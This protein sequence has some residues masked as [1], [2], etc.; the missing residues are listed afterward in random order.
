MATYTFLLT[1]LEGS[2]AL[3]EKH[4]DVMGR[5]LVRMEEIVSAAVV[6]NHGIVHKVRG[7]GDSM[8]CTFERAVDAIV[9]ARD[10]AR[11]L[12]GER[13]E[14]IELRVRAGLHT[15]EVPERDGEFYGGTVNRVARLRGIAA[16][17]QILIS[18]RT[19]E[20]ASESLPDDLTLADLGEHGLR[21][22]SRPEHVYELRS[23]GLLDGFPPLNSVGSRPNN[24]PVQVS[25]FVGREQ[26]IEQIA[27]LVPTTPLITLTA[28]GGAG[29]TR[30]ALH[31]SASLLEG[32]PD[33]VWLV[34]LGDVSDPGLLVQ[35]LA[36]TVGVYDRLSEA[37]QGDGAKLAM[38]DR[39][40]EL[41]A[42]RKTLIVLD[43]C[44]HLVAE[45]AR[46]VDRIVHRCADIRI[47]ATSREPL[48]V[49]GERVFAVPSLST[50]GAI[51]P[52]A[53][54]FV[55]RARLA[56]PGFEID[57]RTAHVVE[58][59]LERLD[60]LPLAIEL[61]ASRLR[62]LSIDSLASRLDDAFRVLTG[63]ARAV[64]RHRTLEATITWSH[65]L[66]EDAEKVLFRRLS[67]FAGGFTLQAAES[68]CGF[69]PLGGG[70]ILDLLSALVD[71]SLVVYDDATDRYR[72][73][74]IVGQFANRKLVESGESDEV[75][76]R[77]T[78]FCL[79]VAR[80]AGVDSLFNGR[81]PSN[82]AEIDNVRS[83]LTRA[84]TDNDR[85]TA[86]RMLADFGW[87][88]IELGLICEGVDR[89]RAA[90]DLPGTAPGLDEQTLSTIANF[91][92]FLGEW[93]AWCEV[94]TRAEAGARELPP[95]LEKG[96]SLLM[97]AMGASVAGE[98]ERARALIDTVASEPDSL[99]PNA[100]GVRWVSILTAMI[101]HDFEA[102]LAM[103]PRVREICGSFGWTLGARNCDWVT[104][105]VWTFDGRLAEARA[106]L[107][108]IV[109][110]Q[111]D[112]S[113]SGAWWT[114]C[115][116]EVHRLEG[117]LPGAVEIVRAVLERG[118]TIG[119][120]M[121]SWFTLIQTIA[122]FAHAG[123]ARSAGAI[124]GA[125]DAGRDGTLGSCWSVNAWLEHFYVA[126]EDLLGEEVHG[127]EYRSGY[128][129]GRPRSLPQVVDAAVAALAAIH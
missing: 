76:R 43:N 108:P 87:A 51:S 56:R 106:L 18:A 23:A 66:L 116:A 62:T 75:G 102:V 122:L 9:G 45:S 13:P 67:V 33:G 5:A 46:I 78:Q 115:L 30:L 80:A 107:E 117:D 114:L 47:I 49:D 98:V 32:F 29:K 58:A 72:L 15:G 61:A 38:E 68:V 63:G 77:H 4:P 37:A 129:E 21:D 112:S 74:H 40:L 54:L 59:V 3:W 39:A 110:D 119:V 70:D 60:G 64:E 81:A 7:E 31:A 85:Q 34:R 86:L 10:F 12:A 91:H 105:I 71:R 101:D 94:S 42:Q 48:G 84:M 8:F 93:N 11:Q 97:L 41:L 24:L 89:T 52:A 20:L 111:G 17:G 57:D 2:T 6:A 82:A 113:W 69:E 96:S 65:D 16:G 127:D 88:W 53:Q 19:G 79:P 104:A 35:T 28:V 73:L 44:E 120:P 128:A 27:A 83:A 55:D 121:V 92:A 50:R 118:S 26:E 126:A 124:Q 100:V 36:E 22:L 1:D 125:L 95:S 90:L 123:D 103:C 99:G 109:A 14:G 25:T